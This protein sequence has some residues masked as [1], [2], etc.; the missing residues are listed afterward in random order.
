MADGITTETYVESMGPSADLSWNLMSHLE[1]EVRYLEHLSLVF[2]H[3]EPLELASWV[4][5]EPGGQYARR[6]RF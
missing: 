1:H 5:A 4:S 3:I 6:A 2:A